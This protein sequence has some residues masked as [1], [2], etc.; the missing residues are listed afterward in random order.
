MSTFL[1]FVNGSHLFGTFKHL[2]VFV[3]DYEALFRY[4]FAQAVQRWR[5][6]YAESN[7]PTAQQL[8][9][10]WYVVDS[11]D[12]WDLSSMRSRQHLYE[13]F[14][15]DREIRGRWMTEASRMLAGTGADPGRIEQQAFGMCFDDFKNWYEKKQS[16]LGGMNR[17]YY[18]VET[19]SDFIHMRRCGRWK[20]D[21]LHKVI[22]EKGLDVGFAV[23]LVAMQ[24]YYD[25]AI[26]IAPELEGIPSLSYLKQNGKQVM[27]VE[28]LRGAPSMDGRNR[29]MVSKLKPSVDCVV[30]IF[31]SELV[32]NG[33]ATKG[34]GDNFNLRDV[35]S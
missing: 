31:E 21:L 1:T 18:A 35:E 30:P 23:D 3:D 2:D 22:T 24:S 27:A 19:A 4:T 32:R 15:D 12:E 29:P 28:F 34:E 16:I 6:T 9:V 13:R 14:Q 7:A 20:V 5:A 26:V 33:V 25:A 17:F 8:R 11:M 10:Y